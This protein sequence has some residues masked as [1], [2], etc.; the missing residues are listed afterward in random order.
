MS[1]GGETKRKASL[2]AT[3]GAWL[4]VWT[5]PRDVEVAPPPSRRALAI[6]T[7][8]LVVVVVAAA[9]L[10]VPAIDGS[11]QRTAAQQARADAQ[12]REATRRATIAEQ[13][14]RR[15]DASALLPAAG[16]PVGELV[17]AREALLRK[18]ET[19]ISGDA[20]ARAQAGELEGR[21]QGTACEPYPKRSDRADWP[22]RD[23]DATRGVYDC[24]VFVRA[25]PKTE[26]NVG[27]Q[28]G[29]PFRAVLDFETFSVAW[30]K[31]N[32]V[33]GER[34]VPDPRTVLRLPRACRAAA[35]G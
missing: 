17:S 21:P 35:S 23:P 32:P 11:K 25:V 15:L 14:P 2:P 4:K 26:T 16:A 18:V 29:Y 8:V 13:R 1:T 24:L 31:T 34:V 20:R 22:D 9:A 28:V 6:G 12:R 7:A 27:G 3:V 5:P 19:S 10:I 30:C 33:P